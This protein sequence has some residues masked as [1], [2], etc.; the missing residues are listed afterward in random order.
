[1]V[2]PYPVSG[3]RGYEGV[4]EVTGGGVRGGFPVESE[5]LYYYGG[6]GCGAG[7]AGVGLRRAARVVPGGL[8]RFEPVVE[9]L[10]GVV[11]G[12]GGGRV[13]CVSEFLFV[14]LGDKNY[15]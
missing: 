8:R 12:S 2:V 6:V 5:R 10:V 13:D 9:E 14:F 1:M 4:P 7:V 15:S 11:I 3:V